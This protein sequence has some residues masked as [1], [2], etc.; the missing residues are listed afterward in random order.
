MGKG[1]EVRGA[2]RAGGIPGRL[3][4]A[5]GAGAGGVGRSCAHKAAMHDMTPREASASRARKI[6]GVLRGARAPE[7]TRDHI[8]SAFGAT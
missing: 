1:E 4:S 8:Y 5:A 2:A 3:P 7:H 6:I